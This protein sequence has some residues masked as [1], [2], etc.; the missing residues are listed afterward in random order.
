MATQDDFVRTALRVDPQDH[1]RIHELASRHGRTFNA[2][3]N[4]AIKSHIS[5]HSEVESAS[6][7][8]LSDADVERIAQRVA[9]LLKTG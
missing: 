7:A 4:V 2:E 9:Q 1:R 3:L 6:C 8:N 5:A